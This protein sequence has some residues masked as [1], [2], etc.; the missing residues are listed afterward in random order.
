MRS[1]GRVQSGLEKAARPETF[2]CLPIKVVLACKHIGLV[3]GVWNQMIQTILIVLETVLETRPDT[4]AGNGAA[5][6]AAS[7]VA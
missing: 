1:A 2:F 5:R 4:R 7:L 6:R 3:S